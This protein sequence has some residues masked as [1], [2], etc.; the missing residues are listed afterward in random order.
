MKSTI[1]KRLYINRISIS[2]LILFCLGHSNIYTQDEMARTRMSLSCTQMPESKAYLQAR[3]LA[4]VDGRYSPQP[5]FEISFYHS[6]D[7]SETLIDKANTNLKGIAII[8][9]ENTR[10][11]NLAEDSTLNFSAL[12]EGS[13]LYAESNDEISI[14]RAN[15]EVSTSSDES[16]KSVSISAYP[17]DESADPIADYEIILSVPRMYSDLILGEEYTDEEGQAEFI[18]P[19]GIPGDEQGNL[20]LKVR[21]IDTDDYGDLE[22]KFIEPWGV[23][24]TQVIESNRELWSPDAPLWMVITF[25]ILMIAVWSHFGIMIRQLV[26]LNNLGK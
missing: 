20:D 13:D 17:Q 5:N 15:I 25:G 2:L 22:I 10:L 21:V 8:Q 7:E 3:L 14:R 4:R 26:K 11:F 9:L 6:D 16:E 1:I 19:D 24:K 12:Y 23:P 18:V